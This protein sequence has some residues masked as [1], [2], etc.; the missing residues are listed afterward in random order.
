MR[1]RSFTMLAAF[2][3]AGPSSV[4]LLPDEDGG[5]GAVAIL[6]PGVAGETLVS[7]PNSRA[8]LG[9]SQPSVRPL[10]AKG[11]SANEAQLLG[12]SAR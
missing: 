10:G 2:A 5:H 6:K 8:T 7:E 3:L 12:G 4:V 9:G 11:L 1:R